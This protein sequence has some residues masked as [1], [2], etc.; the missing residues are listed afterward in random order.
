MKMIVSLLLSILLAIAL[1]APSL[2]QVDNCC[3]IGRTCAADSEWQQGWYDYRSGQCNA[4]DMPDVELLPAT[5]YTFAGQGRLVTSPFLLT[6]G[7]WNIRFSSNPPTYLA[8][9]IAQIDHL[10]NYILLEEEKRIGACV[11]YPWR[12]QA[13]SKP[14]Y[15]G[16]F[17]ARG[18]VFITIPCKVELVTFAWNSVEQVRDYT[19]TFVIRKI[20]TNS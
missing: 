17:F 7:Q 1:A 13:G 10:G 4:P 16:T 19:W 12:S 9:L 3:Q 6:P 5:S 18:D 2:A 11:G 15:G 20:D 8:S 14:S